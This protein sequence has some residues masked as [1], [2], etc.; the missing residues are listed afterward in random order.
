MPDLQLLETPRPWPCIWTD[1]GPGGVRL[2]PCGEMT[3]AHRGEDPFCGEHLIK[4]TKELYETVQRALD[5]IRM[6]YTADC[7]LHI[8]EA[9]VHWLTTFGARIQVMED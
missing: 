8:T 6:E 2:P 5:P 1:L 7:Q 9:V 3:Y 4:W